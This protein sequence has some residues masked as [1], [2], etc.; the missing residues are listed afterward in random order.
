MACCALVRFKLGI[1]ES[2]W[3]LWNFS[4]LPFS[5]R[6]LWVHRIKVK[7]LWYLLANEMYTFHRTFYNPRLSLRTAYHPV[8]ITVGIMNILMF[9]F[10]SAL[11]YFSVCLLWGLKWIAGWPHKTMP[12]M[13]MT[14]IGERGREGQWHMVHWMKRTYCRKKGQQIEQCAHWEIYGSWLP[15]S[16]SKPMFG[17]VVRCERNKPDT[18]TIHIIIASVLRAQKGEPQN[19]NPYYPHDEIHTN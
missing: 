3:K 12:L 15:S 16:L 4:W 6:I 19:L 9:R 10:F 5:I 1:F 7:V 8:V 13:S 2:T 11:A 17:M 18:N 14:P